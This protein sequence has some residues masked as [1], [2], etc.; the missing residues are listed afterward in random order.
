[1]SNKKV[2]LKYVFFAC[3]NSSVAAVGGQK[4]GDN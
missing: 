2:M 4:E 3:V 1:M